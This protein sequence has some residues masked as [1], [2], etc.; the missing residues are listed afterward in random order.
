MTLKEVGKVLLKS[1]LTIGLFGFLY[2]LLYLASGLFLCY[3]DMRLATC[4]AGVVAIESPTLLLFVLVV[5]ALL[6][7]YLVWTNKSLKNHL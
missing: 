1:A 4:D 7:M 2:V 6:S 3:F 5:S